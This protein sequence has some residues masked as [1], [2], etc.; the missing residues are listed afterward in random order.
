MAKKPG[1]WWQCKNDECNEIVFFK[2]KELGSLLWELAKGGW[3]KQSLLERPCK[4]CEQA[5][6]LYITYHFPPSK[7]AI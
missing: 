5:K 1:Y 6:S 3:E 7:E 4:K 2:K